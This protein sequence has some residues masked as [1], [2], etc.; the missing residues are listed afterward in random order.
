MNFIFY[1]FIL[2]FSLKKWNNRVVENGYDKL[3]KITLA[4]L[5]AQVALASIY[6]IIVMFYNDLVGSS[7]VNIIQTAFITISMIPLIIDWNAKRKLNGLTGQSSIFSLISMVL[8]IVM[9]VYMVAL[10]PK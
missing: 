5:G 10:A 2:F 3:T 9:M 8:I 1:L 7:L 6:F 4:M